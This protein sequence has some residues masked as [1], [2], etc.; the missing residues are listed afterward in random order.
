MRNSLA[1][2]GWAAVILTAC[3]DPQSTTQSSAEQTN[4]SA[5]TAEMLQAEQRAKQIEVKA[6]QEA[7]TEAKLQA[8]AA[9]KTQMEAEAAARILAAKRAKYD[10]FKNTALQAAKTAENVADAQKGAIEDTV[11]LAKNKTEAAAATATAVEAAQV[12]FD[13]ATT[14]SET[15]IDNREISHGAFTKKLHEIKGSWA[16]LI[17]EG[18][19]YLQFDNAFETKWFDDL[20]IRFSAQKF[21]AVN[22]ENANEDSLL[23]SPLH[24]QSGAQNYLIPDEV[25]LDVFKSILIYSPQQQKISGGTNIR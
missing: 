1:I 15:S 14:L 11:P 20:Q 9:A 16:I 2:F 25:D 6:I 4:L 18:Q 21:E 7:A 10:Q 23:L 8:E 13:E 3:S 5:P 19:R 24:A 12:N 22:D 17:E